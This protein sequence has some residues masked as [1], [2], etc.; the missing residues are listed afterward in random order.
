[1]TMI[2]ATDFDPEKVRTLLKH[3]KIL[4]KAYLRQTRG[5]TGGHTEVLK[6]IY[7]ALIKTDRY[8]MEQYSQIKSTHN[9]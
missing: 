5:K 3:N 4:E 1:M 8:Y 6:G 7:N 9:V 2:V